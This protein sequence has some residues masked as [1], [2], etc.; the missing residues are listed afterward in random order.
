VITGFLC[1]NLREIENLEDPGLDVRIILRCIF[2]NWGVGPWTGS[3]WLRI[4]GDG[5]NL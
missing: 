4:G 3:S 5:G 2:R 1:G